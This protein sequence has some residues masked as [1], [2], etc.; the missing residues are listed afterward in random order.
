MKVQDVKRECTACVGTLIEFSNSETSSISRLLY[1]VS[2][3][4]EKAVEEAKT[5]AIATEEQYNEHDCLSATIDLKS[6]KRIEWLLTQMT[7]REDSGLFEI[8]DADYRADLSY[9]NG[10]QKR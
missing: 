1:K 4:V 5:T 3:A 9:I 8:S 6:L 2:E 10:E 7:R